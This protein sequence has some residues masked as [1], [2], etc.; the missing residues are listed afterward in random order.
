MFFCDQCGECCRNLDKSQI[1]Q[2]LHN[3]DGICRYLKGNLCTIYEN[4][5]LLCRVEESYFAFFKNQMTLEE[6]YEK[7]YEACKKLKELKNKEMK[8]TKDL[9]D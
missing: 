7:N 6:Y 5:P 4:R 3:G 8:K 2:L 1:Y 9:E